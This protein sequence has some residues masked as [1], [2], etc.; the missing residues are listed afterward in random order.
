MKQIIMTEE[1]FNTFLD[2]TGQIEVALSYEHHLHLKDK[3]KML[4]QAYLKA[5]QNGELK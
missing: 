4:Y 2:K 1:Q 3:R 5:K